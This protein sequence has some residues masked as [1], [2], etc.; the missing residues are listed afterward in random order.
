LVVE[1]VMVSLSLGADHQDHH[2]RH[3]HQRACSGCLG[4][5]SREHFLPTTEEVPEAGASEPPWPFGR[6]EVRTEC[7]PTERKSKRLKSR[8]LSFRPL[9]AKWYVFF[10]HFASNGRKDRILDF[11]LFDFALSSRTLSGLQSSRAFGSA[12]DFAF[13]AFLAGGGSTSSP[14][15][16]SWNKC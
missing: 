1:L 16:S 2:Q 4:L 10:Y 15:S 5:P 9:A 14:P 11:C 12:A 6:V 7:D 13:A 8:I 3:L